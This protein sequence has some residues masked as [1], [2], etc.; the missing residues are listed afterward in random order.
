[1][2][3]FGNLIYLIAMIALARLIAFLNIFHL[4]YFLFPPSILSQI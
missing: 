4:F 3:T 2:Q 1:M